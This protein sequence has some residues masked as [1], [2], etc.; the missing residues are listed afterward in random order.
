MIGRQHWLELNKRI[1]EKIT[2]LFL[3][4][5]FSLAVRQYMNNGGENPW[6]LKSSQ[7]GKSL[8]KREGH[9][10]LSVSFGDGL[11]FH[12]CAIY[13]VRSEGTIKSY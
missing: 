6:C 11:M 5:T 10:G 1:P 9:R 4:M 2:A 8:S 7:I 13:L 12:R 3:H